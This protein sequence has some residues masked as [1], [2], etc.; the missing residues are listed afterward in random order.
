MH[1]RLYFLLR[2]DSIKLALE[3]NHI[4]SASSFS[5]V[6]KAAAR[7]GESVIRRQRNQINI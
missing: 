3:R 1:K 6:G 7:G 5:G 4:V 2:F